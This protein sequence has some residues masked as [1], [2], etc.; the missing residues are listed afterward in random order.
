MGSQTLTKNQWLDNPFSIKLA[1]LRWLSF[2]VLIRLQKI[3]EGIKVNIKTCPACTGKSRGFS[4]KGKG[5]VGG[6]GKYTEKEGEGK[7]RLTRY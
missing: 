3:K 5:T 7:K 4:E 2:L 6:R 1:A